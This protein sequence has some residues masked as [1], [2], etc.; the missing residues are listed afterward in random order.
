MLLR[1]P[2]LFVKAAW[3]E[4]P[5]AGVFHLLGRFAFAAAEQLMAMLIPERPF[6]RL[7]SASALTAVG[8]RMA[9]V[10]TTGV[11]DFTVRCK[12]YAASSSVAVPCLTTT[13]DRSG[14]S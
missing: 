9:P 10:T 11:D 7:R 5:I 1:D 2:N 6:E 12:K 8:G 3:E 4:L 14:S 13:P